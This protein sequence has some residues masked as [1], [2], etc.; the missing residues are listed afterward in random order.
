MSDTRGYIQDNWEGFTFNNISFHTGNGISGIITFQGTAYNI[1]NNKIVGESTNVASSSNEYTVSQR[2]AVS[3]GPG[4][5][6]TTE[7][8]IR[9][10]FQD[11][12]KDTGIKIKIVS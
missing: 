1:E 2:N 4:K 11:K 3:S 8:D 6:D 12:L 5:I 9:N 10:V 7:E